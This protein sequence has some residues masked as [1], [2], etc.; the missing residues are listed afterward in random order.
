MYHCDHL[1]IPTDPAH[2]CG[3]C[4][5]TPGKANLAESHFAKDCPLLD[6]E[7][8]SKIY[9]NVLKDRQVIPQ[10]RNMR[11]KQLDIDIIEAYYRLSPTTPKPRPTDEY[12]TPYNP[13]HLCTI[14]KPGSNHVNLFLTHTPPDGDQSPHFVLDCERLNAREVA[15]QFAIF[16]R[17]LRH[18]GRCPADCSGVSRELV[19][20]V[21]TYYG[22]QPPDNTP[23]T[24]PQKPTSST[25][26][27]HT[28]AC[29]TEPNPNTVEERL[30]L[31]DSDCRS[32]DGSNSTKADFNSDYLELSYTFVRRDSDTQINTPQKL[33][34]STRLK[35]KDKN[36]VNHHRSTSPVPHTKS[37]QGVDLDK[38]DTTHTLPTGHKGATEPIHLHDVTPDI[39]NTEP[40]TPISDKGTL[41]N[42]DQILMTTEN[43]QCV[44]T[45]PVEVAEREEHRT[46][47]NSITTKH[48]ENHSTPN[49]QILQPKDCANHADQILPID[50]KALTLA[51]DF[52]ERGPGRIDAT[53][54]T[55]TEYLDHQRKVFSLDEAHQYGIAMADPYLRVVPPPPIPVA[56][57]TDHHPTNSMR[58]VTTE[59]I[60]TLVAPRMDT[61]PEQRQ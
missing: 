40:T 56:H 59:Q 28:S 24:I 11:T 32:P 55:V 17:A 30:G 49:K 54:T 34:P 3:A 20:M 18:I 45:S 16:D 44:S 15:E 36:D 51:T 60:A 8:M 35:S 27:G 61:T 4:L 41:K 1:P 21:G 43:H 22:L 52:P 38:D 12:P 39:S 29:T 46:S 19:N 14:C 48:P 23:T 7:W 6:R 13:D 26:L 5:T 57:W 10:D 58:Q 42:T 33:I 31:D 2:Y 53:T 9:H 25:E 37:D 47:P 50:E